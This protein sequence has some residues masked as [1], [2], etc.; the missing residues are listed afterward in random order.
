M[1]AL[2]ELDARTLKRL[3][4]LPTPAHL[5]TLLTASQ[6]HPST[7]PNLVSF[8]LALNSV[9]P[10]HRDRVLSTVLVYTG[11][12]LLRELYRGYVRGSPIG[13]DDNPGALMGGCWCCFIL[14]L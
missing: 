10:A 9:W 7:R 6:S 1:E 11:G 8:F 3:R 14:P 13:R 5:N 4:S 12:G 2:P